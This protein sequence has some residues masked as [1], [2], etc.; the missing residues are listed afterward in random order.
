MYSNKVFDVAS[1]GEIR[2]NREHYCFR[3]STS[4]C[5]KPLEWLK[6]EELPFDVY[7]DGS[8]QIIDLKLKSG[9]EDDEIIYTLVMPREM[10][11]FDPTTIS[12]RLERA[13]KV[14]QSQTINDKWAV[15]NIPTFEIKMKD[16]MIGQLRKMG[17][18]APFSPKNADFSHLFTDHTD[19]PYLK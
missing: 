7:D 1:A 2:R 19:S 4:K 14:W 16:D 3:G 8:A 15:V 5:E 10:N 9:S 6:S 13:E 11:T 18:H 12:A 17:I